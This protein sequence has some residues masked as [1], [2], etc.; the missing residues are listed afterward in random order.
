M[1]FLLMGGL[2]FVLFI[3]RNQLSVESVLAIVPDSTVMAVLFFMG[4]YAMK[5]LA[6]MVPLALLYV[7]VGRVFPLYSAIFINVIGLS[8]ATTLP[9][10]IGRYT[11]EGFVTHLIK[12]HPKASQLTINKKGNQSLFAFVIRL[13]AIIPYDLGSMLMGSLKFTFGRYLVIS[14][15]VKL[16]GLV[17]QSFMGATSQNIGSAGFWISTGATVA[18]TLAYALFYKW[19]TWW[20]ISLEKNGIVV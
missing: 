13:I 20:Q 10:L 11:G 4:L 9:Y 15:L 8:L 5:S 12:R 16:P 1:P 18:I 2:L 6:V 19:M 7:S 14:I 17:A 3:K